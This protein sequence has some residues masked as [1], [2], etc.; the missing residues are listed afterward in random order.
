M[1]IIKNINLEMKRKNSK[2]KKM[3]N[4][5]KLDEINKKIKKESKV[6]IK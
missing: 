6:L 2:I 4:E 5:K 1:Q 3:R